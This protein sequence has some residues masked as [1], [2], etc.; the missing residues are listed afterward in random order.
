MSVRKCVNCVMDTTDQKIEFDEHGVCD[1][2]K[3]FYEKVL[4]T[5]QFGNHS[6]EQLENLTK[7]IK[8]AGK[9]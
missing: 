3:T 5:W 2:C 8:K 4:P 6:V 9:N 1:H 7:K